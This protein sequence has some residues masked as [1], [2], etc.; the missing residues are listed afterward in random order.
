VAPYG[1]RPPAARGRRLQAAVECR[2][3]TKASKPRRNV[4]PSRPVVERRTGQAARPSIGPRAGSTT[5]PAA[6]DVPLVGR[7]RGVGTP[8][9]SRW[10]GGHRHHEEPATQPPT[11]WGLG[12]PAPLTGPDLMGGRRPRQGFVQRRTTRPP[13][14]CGAHAGQWTGRRLVVAVLEPDPAAH[15]MPIARAAV[16]LHDDVGA[17]AFHDRQA[18]PSSKRYAACPNMGS[19]TQDAS[20]TDMAGGGSS[21]RG[22]R[23]RGP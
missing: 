16:H 4:K 5:V 18:Q 22:G 14:R 6:H 20:N 15:A 13:S 8:G 7:P 19:P 12:P 23:R 2:R 3:P 17:Y 1:P 11:L 9:R 21:R 10:P